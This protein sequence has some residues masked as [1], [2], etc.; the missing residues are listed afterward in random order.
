MDFFFSKSV[1]TPLKLCAQDSLELVA[2][3]AVDDEVSGGIENEEPVHE[4]GEAEEPGRGS[5]V[6]TPVNVE[7][8]DVR[9]Y[10]QDLH[11]DTVGHEELSTVDDEPGEVTEK[12]HKDNA[13]KDASQVHFIVGGTV[14]VGPNMGIPESDTRKD[15]KIGWTCLT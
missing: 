15:K 10:E 7:Y 2:H 12:K 4:A 14:T 1:M 3:E 13:D 5:E 9:D 11:E 8:Q 6:G